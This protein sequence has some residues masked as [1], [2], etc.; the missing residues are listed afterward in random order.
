MRAIQLWD[1]LRSDMQD[2]MLRLVALLAAR[3]EE[4][5]LLAR[6]QCLEYVVHAMLTRL[7]SNIVQA[8]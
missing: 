2:S 6:A 1:T 5:G 3:D 4:A 8:T 7:H